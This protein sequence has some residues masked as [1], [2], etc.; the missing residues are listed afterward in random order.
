MSQLISD[1]VGSTEDNGSPRRVNQ[2][3]I[4]DSLRIRM[5][6]KFFETNSQRVCLY[7]ACCTKIKILMVYNYP[8]NSESDTKL[9][10][11]NHMKHSEERSVLN[12]MWEDPAVE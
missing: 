3:A 9:N 11:K 8:E 5:D 4:E 7:L 6:E 10:V 2:N 12:I 1:D